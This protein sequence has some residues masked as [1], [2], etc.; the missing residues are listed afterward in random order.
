MKNSKTIKSLTRSFIV[1][2]SLCPTLGFLTIETTFAQEIVNQEYKPG[3]PIYDKWDQFYKIE[4]VIPPTTK[5]LTEARGY[6]VADYQEFLEKKWM[7]NR[8]CLILGHVN[9]KRDL[10]PILHHYVSQVWWDEGIMKA[11]LVVMWVLVQLTE[12][13]NST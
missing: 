6:V 10:W 11:S 7:G 1:I 9:A 8:S 13:M 12:E 4:K 2:G 3:N 5:T